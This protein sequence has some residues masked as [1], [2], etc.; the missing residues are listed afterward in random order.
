MKTVTIPK[1]HICPF[2]YQ[3]ALK[4]YAKAGMR[5][6]A[7]RSSSFR[8]MKKFWITEAKAISEAALRVERALQ[9]R[10]NGKPAGGLLEQ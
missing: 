9:R 4:L 10:F 7:S 5:L 2:T 1:S 8:E 6:G 3:G